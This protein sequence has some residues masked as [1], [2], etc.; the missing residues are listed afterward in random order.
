MPAGI[1][2]LSITTVTPRISAAATEVPDRKC[3]PRGRFEHCRAPCGHLAQRQVALL[4]GL[5]DHLQSLF[6]VYLG[7][8]PR[9]GGLVVFINRRRDRIKLLSWDTDPIAVWAKRLE[10]A[11]A[12][13]VARLAGFHNHLEMRPGD[14]GAE[15]DL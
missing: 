1:V 6:D 5:N 8:D 9:G 13:D 2:V 11:V 12:F 15:F 3:I 4:E 14:A 10:A 7:R